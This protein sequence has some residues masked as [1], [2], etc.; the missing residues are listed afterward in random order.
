MFAKFIILE[1]RGSKQ[2]LIPVVFV[3]KIKTHIRKDRHTEK[4]VKAVK[5]ET[6]VQAKAYFKIRQSP[7]TYKNK[8]YINYLSLVVHYISL[9][10]TFC[11]PFNLNSSK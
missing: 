8:I 11:L 10:Q 3:F 1:F 2:P 5:A 7:L 6:K 4:A 9:V